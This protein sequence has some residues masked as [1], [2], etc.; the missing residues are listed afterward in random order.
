MKTTH[1]GLLLL[2]ISF[3]LF[4]CKPG[5]GKDPKPKDLLGPFWE[6]ETVRE[7]FPFQDELYLWSGKCLQKFDPATESLSQVYCYKNFSAEI[8]SNGAGEF[9]LATE[10]EGII[11]LG[12]NG[13]TIAT[14]TPGNSCL[15]FAR[16]GG[17]AV[18]QAG[19]IWCGTQEILQ[20]AWTGLDHEQGTGLILFDPTNNTCTV[21]D[22]TN[23]EIPA[24]TIRS[25]AVS[26]GKVYFSCVNKFFLEYLTYGHAEVESVIKFEKSNG[27]FSLLQ[28]ADYGSPH[29]RNLRAWSNDKVTYAQYGYYDY[30]EYYRLFSGYGVELETGSDLPLEYGDYYERDANQRFLFG[31]TRWLELFNGSPVQGHTYAYLR[32]N[33]TVLLDQGIESA[34]SE[35]TTIFSL[36][37]AAEEEEYLWLGT[38]RGLYRINTQ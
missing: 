10:E 28:T 19:M 31:A 7:I 26:E 29:I 5:E 13:Q 1:I 37:Q 4:S 34:L 2:L 23:S 38:N 18:D 11:H 32:Q 16:I 14:Y 21:W 25:V 33:E 8:F 35:R 24:N 12:N 36:Y 3:V 27:S 15:P 6:E 30:D 20:D 17:L 9:F 22:T